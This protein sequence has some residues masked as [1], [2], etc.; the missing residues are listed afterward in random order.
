[1]DGSEQQLYVYGFA[2]PGLP[3]KLTVLRRP[4]RTLH[5]HGLDAIVESVSGRPQPTIET[6]Q[7]QHAL[8]ERLANRVSAFLPARFGSITTA[9]AL[10]ALIDE[11]QDVIAGTLARI[12]GCVQM[13]IRVF[14]PPDTAR[15]EATPRP[16][17]TAYL[18]QRREQAHHVPAEVEVIRECLGGCTKDERVER[19]ERTL[20]VTVF[21]L[22]ARTSLDGYRQKASDLPALLAPYQVTITGPAPVF[23]FAPELL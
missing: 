18:Q 11:H 20:R 6:L 9:P 7:A 1:M 13:T 4:L 10:R 8:V 22:V 17:G 21:H 16:S 12:S 19:G 2:V 5:V 23:A 15:A 3:G 14:G